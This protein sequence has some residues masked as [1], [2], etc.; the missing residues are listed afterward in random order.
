MIVETI[1]M[2]IFKNF[3]LK[4]EK[5]KEESNE[6]ALLFSRFTSLLNLIYYSI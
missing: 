6:N 2:S 1:K 3:R 5:S 4:I